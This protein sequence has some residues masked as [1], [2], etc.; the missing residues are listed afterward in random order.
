MAKKQRLSN[1][2]DVKQ[3]QFETAKK[4]ADQ[5]S[6]FGQRPNEIAERTNMK[7]QQ[8]QMHRQDNK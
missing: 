6:P 3:Q 2:A 1:A 5:S 4:K 8:K 7:R